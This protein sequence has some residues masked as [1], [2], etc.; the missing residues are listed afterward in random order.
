MH[1]M[2]SVIIPTYKRSEQL[3]RA[4]KSVLNQT[5][6][7]FEIIIVDD[8]D[9]DSVYRKQ[10]ECFMERY[11]NDSRIIY[12]K[13]HHNLNGAAARNTGIKNAQGKYVTF[14]D[15]DDFYLNE[16]LEKQVDFLEK[17]MQYDA[18]YC[19][20]NQRGEDVKYFKSGD[21]S[22][23]ILLES[24]SPTT[25]SLMFRKESL[26]KLNG[27]NERYRRHQDYELLLRFFQQG[28]IGVVKN[29]LL[30][31]GENGGENI[32]KA[33]EFEILKQQYLKEFESYIESLSKNNK[34][35][36]RKVYAKQYF[37]LVIAFLKE[38]KLL[39]ALK[40]YF[41]ALI[42]NF[43]FTQ[44]QLKKTMQLHCQ[45]KRNKKN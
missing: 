15:D 45:N 36:K 34:V 13:H 35:L 27:F 23:E 32:P 6:P 11:K 40:Y 10:T 25:P 20:R 19:W 3:G 17:N 4:I 31:I 16:K 18:V 14:L 24:F 5:Y 2:V 39:K 38:K 7:Y 28:K 22:E 26:V 8:N 43:S 37:D 30:V 44:N 1:N 42:K 12:I 33:C 9:S 21:L 41:K 29:V